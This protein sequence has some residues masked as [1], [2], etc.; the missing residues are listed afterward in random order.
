MLLAEGRPRE[1]RGYL[2]KAVKYRPLNLRAGLLLLAA[3]AAGLFVRDK[4]AT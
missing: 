2:A 4:T 1:A 3:A